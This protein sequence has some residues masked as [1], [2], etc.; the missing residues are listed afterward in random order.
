MQIDNYAIDGEDDQLLELL[1][2]SDMDSLLD[3]SAE[4]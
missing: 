3:D 1:D 2:D 4:D